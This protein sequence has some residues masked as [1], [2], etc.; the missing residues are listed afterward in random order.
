MEVH[1]KHGES[2]FWEDD[3]GGLIVNLYIPADANWAKRNAALTL[4]TNYPFAP[5]STLTFAKVKAGRFP[6]ALR[7]PGWAAGKAVVKVNGQPATPVFERGYAVVDRRWKAG[8]TVSISVPLE[9]RIEAAPGDENTIAVLS[10]PMVLAADLGPKEVKWEQADPALVGADLLAAFSP[11]DASKGIFNTRGVVRPADLQFVPFYRQYNRR[12]ATYFKR[13]SEGAWAA[14]E[15]AFLAEQARLKDIAARSVDVMFLG[16]MQPERDHNLTSEIS[17][18][19][20]YRGRQGRDARSGGFIEFSLKPK[21]GPLIL[22]ATYWGGERKRNFDI[23]VD[24]VKIATQTLDN[25]KPGKF[26]D[27][28]YPLPEPLTKGK[29]EVRVRIV[30]HDRSTA[31]PIFGVRLFTAKPGAKI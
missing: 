25:D 11:A 10:G 30:P 31:G 18:P 3:A 23:L 12:S 14:E 27:V 22:Q 5:E 6:V 2:I 1:A 20:T 15:K 4:E 26:F 17:Y 19:V 29:K 24:N 8:D 21:D 9:L 16:E 13:F 7:V 28:E